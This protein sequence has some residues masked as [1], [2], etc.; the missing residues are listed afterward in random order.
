MYMYQYTRNLA[1]LYETPADILPHF[2]PDRDIVK[3]TFLDVAR[4]DR[5]ILTEPEADR[6]M[7]AYQIPVVPTLVASTPEECAAAAGEIGFPVAIKI[8]SPDVSHKFDVSGVALNVS[9]AADAAAQFTEVTERVKKARPKAPIEGVVVQPMRSKGHQLIIGSKKDPTFGPA[10]IF[11]MGGTSVEYH[12]DVAV[13]FPPLNQALARSMIQG[14][15]V[16]QL[17]NGYR[18]AEPVDIAALEQTMVKVSYLLVDFPEI[19]EMDINPLLANKDGVLALNARIVID[20]RAVRRITL[21]GS[22]LMISMYPSKYHWEMP[23]EGDTIL[24][25]AIRPEDEPLWTDMI[26]SLSPDSAQYRFFGPL[27]EITREMIIRY[28]HIDYDREIAL[29]AIRKG[30]TGASDMMLGVAQLMIETANSSEGEF[31]ILVRDEFQ[32]KGI[33]T[34]LMETLIQAARD[35]HVLKVTGQVLTINVRM[36]HF[37]ENLGFDVRASNEHDIHSLTLRL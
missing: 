22:H 5:P 8:L 37:A 15:K 1:N 35:R 12:H 34:K 21:P 19:L 2:E 36:T 18:G 24:I 7:Q 26:A 3:K 30:K 28:C 32:G 27:R 6:V 17:L 20:P 16:S 9:S 33:G 31:A 14:T 4:E 11:G 13:D 25:R 23:L 10:L 29:V